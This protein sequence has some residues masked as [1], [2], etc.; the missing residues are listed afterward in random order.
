MKELY[1]SFEG[2]LGV[3]NQN[4]YII[5]EA[6]NSLLEIEELSIRQDIKKYRYRVPATL[7]PKADFANIQKIG[8]L[9]ADIWNGCYE[10]GQIFF[11]GKWY[12]GKKIAE[13]QQKNQ[14]Q[15]WQKYV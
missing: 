11:K 5:Y 13:I 14:D 4:G 9:Q 1:K 3:E 10:N 7:L 6:D 8:E 2:K 12:S 15:N